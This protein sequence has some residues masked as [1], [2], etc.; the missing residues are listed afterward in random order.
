MFHPEPPI[1]V[2]SEKHCAADKVVAAVHKPAARIIVGQTPAPPFVRGKSDLMIRQVEI[3]VVDVVTRLRLKRQP[4]AR[5]KSQ[6]G[7]EVV[8]SL[9]SRDWDEC[10]NRGPEFR[11]P[12][13][14][15][16]IGA[17]GLQR[18]AQSKTDDVL[19][20]NRINV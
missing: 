15:E 11:P 18:V 20:I 2:E 17:Q 8:E 3:L 1:I 14:F 9:L 5:A 6:V 19:A 7:I 16:A 12:D 4:R 13:F 10:A